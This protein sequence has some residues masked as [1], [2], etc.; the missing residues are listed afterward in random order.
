MELSHLGIE[1]RSRLMHATKEKI[2]VGIQESSIDVY[3]KRNSPEGIKGEDKEILRG[4]NG[5]SVAG[6]Q[7]YGWVMVRKRN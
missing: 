3:L 6:Q 1:A 2:L 7:V 4:E 5:H